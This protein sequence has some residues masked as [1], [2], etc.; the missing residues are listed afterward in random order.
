MAQ[1][2]IDEAELL[3]LKR[4]ETMVGTALKNPVARKQLARAVKE[5]SPDDPLAKEVD[6]V[7]PI[8]QRILDAEKANADLRKELA[9]D[10]ASREHD[11]KIAGLRADQERGFDEL[12]RQK[13][14]SDG[15]EKV[16]KVMEEKGI[17]DVA[18]AATWVESQMPPQNPLTPGG[19]G[20]WGF[21]DAPP[22]GGGDDIKKLIESK[23]EDNA[24]LHKLAQEALAEVRGTSRR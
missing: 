11:A 13:W 4:V 7:D 9:D 2:E 5:I 16:K 12:R 15:I 10:K 1:I 19:S 22:E 6:K 17:L 24:V 3:R 20:T 18:I 21:M 23:G 8:E 14:T